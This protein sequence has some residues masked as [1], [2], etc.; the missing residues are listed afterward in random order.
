MFLMFPDNLYCPILDMTN[1]LANTTVDRTSILYIVHVPDEAFNFKMKSL[2]MTLYNVQWH[3]KYIIVVAT[4]RCN[5]QEKLLNLIREL[6]CP[7]LIL[8]FES[9]TNILLHF[10]WMK[11]VQ[12]WILDMHLIYMTFIHIT[13]EVS[14]DTLT[15]ILT[16][17]SVR[18]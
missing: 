10:V 11:N 9:W 5:G 15:I 17:P 7:D 4:N 1:T 16:S 13:V 12:W 6:N 14:P 8:K 2:H 3:T 18:S